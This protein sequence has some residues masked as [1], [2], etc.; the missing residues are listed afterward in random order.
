[1]AS[2]ELNK[3]LLFN[4]FFFFGSLPLSDSLDTVHEWGH[5]RAR[6][7]LVGQQGR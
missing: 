6:C 3:Q 5:W 4:M 2:E 1:M 7:G